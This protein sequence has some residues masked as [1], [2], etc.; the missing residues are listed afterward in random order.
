MK[1]SEPVRRETRRIAIGTGILCCVMLAVFLII[2]KMSWPVALGAVVGYV[3]AVGNFFIMA[4][5]VQRV[6]DSASGSPDDEK[7]AKA[8]MRLSYNKRMLGIVAILLLTILLAKVSW[9]TAIMPLIF[10]QL[11]I[12]GGQILSSI[13]KTPTDKGSEA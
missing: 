7:R 13:R 2:G 1:L 3:L 5:D 9:I 10:P 11:V 6:V 4:M 12:K 8:R